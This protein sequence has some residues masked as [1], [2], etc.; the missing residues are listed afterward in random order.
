MATAC[1]TYHNTSKSN[2]TPEP[3]FVSVSDCRESYTVNAQSSAKNRA[4]DKSSSATKL[5]PVICCVGL[6]DKKFTKM[7]TLWDLKG[8]PSN[9][10]STP[11]TGMGTSSNGSRPSHG[12]NSG[13]VAS[14][15]QATQWLN[16]YPEDGHGFKIKFCVCVCVFFP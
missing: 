9:Q 11:T 8:M 3:L 7:D 12:V 2:R 15:P 16:E 4:R 5:Q 13:T 14:K 6:L 10:S 1:N